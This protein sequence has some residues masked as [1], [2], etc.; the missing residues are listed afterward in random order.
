MFVSNNVL[1]AQGEGYYIVN[2]AVAVCIN[3]LS[4]IYTVSDNLE[5]YAV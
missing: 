2:T 3:N 4:I 1:C 5:A